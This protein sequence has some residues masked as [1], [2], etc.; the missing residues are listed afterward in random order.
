VGVGGRVEAMRYVVRREV[1]LESFCKNRTLL[2]QK[3]EWPLDMPQGC[4]SSRAGHKAGHHRRG[5]V[6]MP[7]FHGDTMRG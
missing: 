1:Q 7:P 5:T 3:K 6:A 2:T 4:G